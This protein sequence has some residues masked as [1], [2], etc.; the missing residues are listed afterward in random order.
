MTEYKACSKCK[1]IKYKNDFSP[2]KRSPTG[3][4]S[5][6]RKCVVEWRAQN[7]DRIYEQKQKYLAKPESKIKASQFAKAYKERNPELVK[8]IR[9]RYQEKNREQR[10]ERFREWASQNKDRIKANRKK[11][12]D[13]NPDLY[14][15]YSFQRRGRLK[16]NGSF[17]IY[18]KELL[19]LYAMPCFYCESEGGTIDHVIPLSRGGRHSIGNLVSCC[20]S[21]NSSKRNQT[22]TEWKRKKR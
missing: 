20:K 7:K 1:Q 15:S 12:V 22:I 14:R 16:A 18:K 17:I 3:L 19:K 11:A 8:E 13:A 6:C 5:Q 21:C 2:D 4:Q 10:S 9:L